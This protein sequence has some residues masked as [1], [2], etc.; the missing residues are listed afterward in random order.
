MRIIVKVVVGFVFGILG[1]VTALALLDLAILLFIILV[2]GV[3]L[4]CGHVLLHDGGLRWLLELLYDVLMLLKHDSSR[5]CYEFVLFVGRFGIGGGQL[6]D[7][8][9][10]QAPNLVV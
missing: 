1:R 9:L 8:A 10:N 5:W 2:M 6:L 7:E 4:V 3:P